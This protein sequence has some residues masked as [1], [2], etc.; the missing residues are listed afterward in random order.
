MILPHFVFRIPE[1][2]S[3]CHRWEHVYLPL[4]GFD[5]PVR[6]KELM[7]ALL[8]NWCNV[9]L[10]FHTSPYEE[11]HFSTTVGKHIF[12]ATLQCRSSTMPSNN[13]SMSIPL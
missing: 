10:K 8:E 6:D 5:I 9:M 7:F 3:L 12:K 4:L 13:E 1:D 11:Y 2:V